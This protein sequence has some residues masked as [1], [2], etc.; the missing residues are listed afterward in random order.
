MFKGVMTMRINFTT[1]LDDKL[2]EKLKI[3][4]I[5]EKRSLNDILEELIKGYLEQTEQK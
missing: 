1:T 3:R 2:L 5:L 4:A